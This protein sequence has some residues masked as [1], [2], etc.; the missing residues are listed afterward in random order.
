M[1]FGENTEQIK[2]TM[3]FWWTF[4]TGNE[5]KLCLCLF[6]FIFQYKNLKYVIKIQ[7]K[8]KTEKCM[9]TFFKSIG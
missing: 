2:K 8:K 4:L 9:N 3:S 6:S 1:S 5:E 7:E